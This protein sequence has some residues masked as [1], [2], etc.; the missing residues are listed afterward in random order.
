MVRP[1][2]IKEARF[3]SITINGSVISDTYISNSAEGIN[4]ELLRVVCTNISSPGSIWI[5][6][7]GTDIEV[8]RKNDLTSG[9]S[10]FDAYPFIYGVDSTNTTG[11]PQAYFPRVT[12]TK[13]YLAG[14]GFTSGTGTTF[15]PT[16]LYYR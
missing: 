2:R 3:D 8:W 6:E 12:N 9:L 1:N 13:I 4:G 5:A 11:S 14:S 16:Y 10:D 7:S 15:G